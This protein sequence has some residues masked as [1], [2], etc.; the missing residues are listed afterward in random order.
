[1]YR[2]QL[3]RRDTN[4]QQVIDHRR[5]GKT[6]VGTALLSGDSRVPQRQAADMRLIDH[7]LVVGDMWWPVVA[8]VEERVDDNILR[9]VRCAIVGVQTPW[10]GEMVG[11]QRLVPAD[12]AVHRF[13]IR[14]D[15]QFCRVAAVPTTRVVGA[16]HAVAVT[17]AWS[18]AGQ[19]AVPDEAV[20]LCEFDP[21]L[22]ILSIEQA[23][24]HLLGCLGEQGKVGARP[25]PGSAKRIR[26]AWPD[27]HPSPYSPYFSS[28]P[29]V[30]LAVTHGP[31]AAD[32]NTSPDPS[33][34][35]ISRVTRRPG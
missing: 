31:H 6:A 24:F 14:V 3:H 34:L 1:M 16:V 28:I 23:Q 22:V 7:G 30:R 12:L 29:A 5:M 35:V 8:P 13:G 20:N 2:H 21:R 33:V 17:R 27:A 19:V 25:V 18:D 10:V 9:H 26:G 4:A 32:D 15:Q 11:E